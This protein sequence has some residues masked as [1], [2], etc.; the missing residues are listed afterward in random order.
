ML[1]SDL[2]HNFVRTHVSALEKLNPKKLRELFE[3]MEKEGTDLLKSEHI[4]KTRIELNY[5]ID[6]RYVKQYHE[7][8][9]VVTQEEV[10]K[11]KLQA[12]ARKFH[13]KHNRLYGYSLEEVG[14]PIEV[15][16]LSLTC[17]GRT[18]KPKF[19]KMKYAGPDPSFAFKRKRK[20]YLPNKKKFQPVPVFDGDRLKY[21]N[22]IEGPA[23]VEQVNTTTF[24]SPEFSVLCDA[25]GSFT[26]YL[27]SREK[28]FKKRVM[29]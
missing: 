9:V 1:M 13:P 12:I 22:K 17:L 14:T 18:D 21:G 6:M 5:S 23:I 15:I 2:Q 3:E 27:K 4:A 10:H 20:V 8:N 24:V 26:M 7:V 29:K 28:E 19:R 25:Y 11:G 16:N